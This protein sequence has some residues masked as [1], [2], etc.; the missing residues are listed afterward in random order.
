[1]HHNTWKIPHGFSF[2]CEHCHYTPVTSLNAPRGTGS[3]S[4]NASSHH[5]PH[6]TGL[7]LTTTHSALAVPPCPV[8][9]LHQTDGDVLLQTITWC[10]VSVRAAIRN[11]STPLSISFE[12]PSSLWIPSRQLICMQGYGWTHRE[13]EMPKGIPWCNNNP[14]RSHRLLFLCAHLLLRTFLAEQITLCKKIYVRV[15]Q[16]AMNKRTTRKL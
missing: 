8:L 12:F 7:V 16:L 5:Q 15:S 2:V 6:E 13:R 3:Q 10:L 4:P 1:M 14:C 9:H 11:V